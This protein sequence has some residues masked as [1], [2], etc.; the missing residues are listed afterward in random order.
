MPLIMEAPTSMFMT[1]ICSWM[2]SSG[3]AP[4]IISPVIAP[5]SAISP[6][7]F[8]LSSPGDSAITSDLLTFIALPTIMPATGMIYRGVKGKTF[9]ATSRNMVMA[10]PIRMEAPAMI[11]PRGT[12]FAR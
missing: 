11:F 7:V 3:E 4:P 12:C 6:T 2:A 10:V 9:S 8:A 1:T 5:G